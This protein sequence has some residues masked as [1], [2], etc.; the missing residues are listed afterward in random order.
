MGNVR[1]FQARCSKCLKQHQRGYLLGLH[2]RRWENVR[3]KRATMD[4]N[5]L[6]CV[7]CGHN[8]YSQSKA[9]WNLYARR[10]ISTI[11]ICGL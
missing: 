5:Y 9:G 7:D 4:G 10:Q 3:W 11:P 6:E 1:N 8:W 2:G